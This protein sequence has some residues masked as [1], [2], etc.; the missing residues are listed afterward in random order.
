MTQVVALTPRQ[1]RFVD[2]FILSGCGAEAA[3]R[4]GYS[5]RTARQ[6][7]SENLTK[8]DIQ[9]AIEAARR[10]EAEYWQLQKH[11][12]IEALLGTIE[13]AKTQ[14]NPAAM[15]RG[16]TEIAKMLGYYEP[17]KV[18]VELSDDA[19]R[20]KAYFAAMTDEDLYAAIA[21]GS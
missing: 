18:K 11:D 5:V 9:A 3:R 1:Q 2:E 12:V 13:M 14:V 7:G 15:I 10:R 6:I 16:L 8:P 20:V 17:E 19:E 4:A 21:A